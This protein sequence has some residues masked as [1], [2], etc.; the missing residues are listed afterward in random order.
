MPIA[1][2]PARTYRYVLACERAL[3]VEQQTVFLLKALTAR[4]HA[5]IRDGLSVVDPQGN[6]LVRQGSGE[7]LILTLGVLGWENF[8]DAQGAPV[9][10]LADPMQKDAN[11]DRL[12]PHHRKELADAVTEMTFLSEA[13]RKN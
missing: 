4:E 7:I 10:F 2:D 12:A 11:W 13:E 1:V 3:P 6:L 8:K 9:A 5:Q